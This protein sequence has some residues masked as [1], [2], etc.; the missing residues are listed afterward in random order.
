M[1]NRALVLS[2]IAL[3]A[4]PLMPPAVLAQDVGEDVG[5]ERKV[6]GEYGF[7]WFYA[8]AA[9]A[10][11]VIG[12]LVYTGVIQTRHQS[13]RRRY[14]RESRQHHRPVLRMDRMRD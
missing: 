10:L 8:L 3:A 7:L 13:L 2:A 11:V 9:L 6:F 5:D 12:L 14:I 1:R 4:L